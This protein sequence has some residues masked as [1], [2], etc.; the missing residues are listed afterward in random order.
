MVELPQYLQHFEKPVPENRILQMEAQG[1][2]A[3]ASEEVEKTCEFIPIA[4]SCKAC[5]AAEPVVNMHPMP[6][7]AGAEATH[8][9]TPEPGQ[10]AFRLGAGLGARASI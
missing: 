9:V 10:F 7:A 2:C 8:S 6:A 1:P 4:S 3:W 5:A